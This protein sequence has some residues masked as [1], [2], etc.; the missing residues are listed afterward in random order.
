MADDLTGA[1]QQIGADIKARGLT[2]EGRLPTAAVAHVKEIAP[3]PYESGLRN[4]S[5][6]FSTRTEGLITVRRRGPSVAFAGDVLKFS[7]TGTFTL[8]GAVPSGFRP[9]AAF[10]AFAVQLSGNDGYRIAIS[11]AGNF[12][13]FNYQGGWVRFYFTFFTDNTPPV[14]P[15]GSNG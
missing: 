11:T 3:A 2:P 15:P 4:I 10:N 5:T 14:T 8:N 13:I 7:N 6:L 12:T 9:D 1:I